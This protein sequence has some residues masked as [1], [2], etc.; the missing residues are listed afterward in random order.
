MPAGFAYSNFSGGSVSTSQV[1]SVRVGQHDGYDRFVIEF[2]GGIP[3][4]TVVRQASA[5]FTRS[6]KGDQVT[7][8]GSAGV[9]ITVQSITNWTGY[10]TP[11]SFKSAYPFMR[12][13]LLI[14]NF[15]GVQQWGIGTAG[16]PALRVF[17]M[18]AP[19]RLVVDVAVV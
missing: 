4:Y 6:P 2:A 17:T 11:T 16:K 10:T 1:A 19:N 15:E 12:E 14:Q 9:V 5:I 8:D 7:L 18:S 3:S 13:A